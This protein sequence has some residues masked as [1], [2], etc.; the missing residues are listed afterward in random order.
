MLFHRLLGC[1]KRTKNVLKIPQFECLPRHIELRLAVPLE[2]TGIALV[3]HGKAEADAEDKAREA[4]K[5]HATPMFARGESGLDAEPCQHD[6]R[7]GAEEVLPHPY[8]HARVGIQQVGNGVESRV[9]IIGGRKH[10]MHHLRDATQ[11]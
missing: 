4:R 9:E 6:G 10:V 8:E 1:P 7:E 5:G 3:D 11:T 2:D